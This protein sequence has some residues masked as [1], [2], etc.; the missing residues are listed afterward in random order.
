MV[1]PS[2]DGPA[3]GDRDRAERVFRR[4]GEYWTVG[5]EGRLV[6]LRDSKGMHDLAVPL[7]HPG[8]ERHVLDLWSGAADPGI[9]REHGVGPLPA[10]SRQP[11]VDEEARTCYRRRLAELEGVQRSTGDREAS[12]ER[13]AEERDWLVRELAATYGLGG[14]ARSVPDEVERARKA[15]YRRVADALRR[16]E[17]VHRDLGRHLRHSVHTGVYCS[18]TPERE[19]RWCT[20]PATMTHRRRT[21]QSRGTI[22]PHALRG[23][24]GR[25]DSGTSSAQSLR[26]PGQS[27]HSRPLSTTGSHPAA[28]SR[29]KGGP[30]AHP[31]GTLSALPA[32]RRSRHPRPAA[33]RCRRHQRRE[34]R[35]STRSPS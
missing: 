6:T 5:F 8:R 27:T 11:L 29:G 9:M 26:P 1:D 32:T 19:L 30:Q 2:A 15:V 28:T 10:A 20:A 7:A 34:D 17:Q 35:P 12:S 24:P 14:R 22:R 25:G 33:D 18:Y 23:R 31:A 16:I 3:P 13:L 21:A 4:N